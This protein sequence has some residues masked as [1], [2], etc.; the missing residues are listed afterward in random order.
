MKPR[1]VWDPGKAARNLRDHHVSFED[2]TD[3]FCDDRS[4][5]ED[6]PDADEERFTI[7]GM[8]RKGLLLVVYTE[9]GEDAVRI[10]SARKAADH[11]VKAYHHR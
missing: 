8:S 5:I 9:R 7:I 1:F 11:E 2:A 10:I 4:V 6:D 3:V